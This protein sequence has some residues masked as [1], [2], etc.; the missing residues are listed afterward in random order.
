MILWRSRRRIEASRPSGA[1]AT[2][3]SRTPRSAPLRAG[4]ALLA[5]VAGR[6]RRGRV[7]VAADASV[8]ILVVLALDHKFRPCGGRG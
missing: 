5:R 7:I 6:D 1:T 4:E 2:V 8:T 3:A